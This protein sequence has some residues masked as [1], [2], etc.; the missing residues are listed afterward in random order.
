MPSHLDNTLSD[1]RHPVDGCHAAPGLAL[2]LGLAAALALPTALHAAEADP[3]TVAAVE[4]LAP[5]L[6]AY[7]EAGMKDFDVP[8]TAIGIVVGDELVY[9]RGFGVRAR[10]GDSAVDPATIFQIGSTTKAFLATTMAIAVDRDLFQ[11]DDK[12]FDLLP[13]FQLLDPWVTREFRMFD[14]LAQRSGLPPYANDDLAS[15]GYDEDAKIHS[16]R[17]VAP[18][19]SF[20]TTFAYTNITHLIAGRIVAS[21][22]GAADWYAVLQ[23]DILDPLG[24]DQTTYTADAIEAAPNHANGHRYHPDG[25]TEIPFDQLFPYDFGGAGA[26]NSSVEQLVPWLRLLLNDG[27]FDGQEIVS[28]RNLA[29]TWMARVALNDAVTYANGWINLATPNGTVTWHNGGTDGFGAFVGLDRARKIGVVVLTNQTN[30]GFPDAVGLWTFDRLQGNPDVDHVANMLERQVAT[31]AAQDETFATPDDAQPP[32]AFGPLVGEFASPVFG[33]ATLS[34]ADDDL[35]LRLAETGAGIQLSPWDGGVFTF[36]LAADGDFAAMAEILGP[37]PRG[38]AA[39]VTGADGQPDTLRLT[40]G[41]GQA[42]DFS[43]DED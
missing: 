31:Y 23:K 5:D 41:D 38:F 4:A 2:V 3:E 13:D 36:R 1:I 16:L 25:V 22:E 9:A 10:S 37:T 33:K 12:V 24:M 42:Y 32:P 11:W 20:R 17:Y 43:R 26:I 18:V 27:T 35:L 8:G 15:F 21:V 7:V 29:A 6:E 39:F 34:Q 19:S 14:L 30:V 28:P 40:F